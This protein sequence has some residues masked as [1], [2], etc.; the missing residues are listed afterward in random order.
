M[1]SATTD[2]PSKSPTATITAKM[3]RETDSTEDQQREEPETTLP[4]R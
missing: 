3:V 2:W 1:P 4:A